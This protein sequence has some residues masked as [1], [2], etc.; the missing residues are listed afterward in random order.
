[1]LA[2]KTQYS[3]ENAQLYFKEHLAVG[4]Y[5]TEGESVAGQWI[6][7]GASMLGLKGNVNQD[8]F[9]GLCENLHPATGELLTQ[10]RK[11][12]RRDVDSEGNEQEVANRRIF[13]DFTVS[14]PKSVSVMAFIGGDERIIDA[15]D[16]AVDSA[17]RGCEK[18][19]RMA[20]L[21]SRLAINCIA[22]MYIKA[23]EC[24]VLTS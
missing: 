12:V 7:K 1:M 5:Y 4:D 16:R 23:S 20:D 18:S 10:R 3:L 14:P 22:A 9:L 13:Y 8:G 15:H 24:S 19:H 17:V 6:G 11:T 21:E 2:P